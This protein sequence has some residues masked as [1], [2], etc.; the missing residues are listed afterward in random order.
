MRFG[1]LNR[2]ELITLLAGAAVS[3]AIKLQVSRHR[4]GTA[5]REAA[6]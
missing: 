2:R 3:S 1:E 4:V 6:K 5:G